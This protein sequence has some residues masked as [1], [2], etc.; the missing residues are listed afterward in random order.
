MKG[1]GT[2]WGSL[3]LA[4]SLSGVLVLRMF[5]IALSKKDS[6]DLPSHLLILTLGVSRCFLLIS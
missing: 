2:L 5:F 6:L 3:L 1:V 4:S